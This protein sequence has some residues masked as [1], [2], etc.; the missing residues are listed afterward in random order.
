L[1]GVKAKNR[2]SGRKMDDAIFVASKI[3]G[4]LTIGDKHEIDKSEWRKPLGVRLTHIALH[5]GYALPQ[6]IGRY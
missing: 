4:D 1:E 2:D 3:S 5:Q 6:T